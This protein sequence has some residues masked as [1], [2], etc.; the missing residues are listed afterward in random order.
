MIYLKERIKMNDENL[1]SIIMPCYNSAK[2]IDD[3]IKS[4]LAQTY[5]NFE[6]IIID[7]NSADDSL[8]II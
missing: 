7:D 5:R 1:V 6:L 3:S 8:H 2:F 4:V